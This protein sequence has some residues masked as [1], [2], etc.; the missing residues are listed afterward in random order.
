[1]PFPAWA[2]AATQGGASI[3]GTL[4]SA[5]FNN[6]T[7]NRNR[8]FDQQSTGQDAYFSNLMMRKQHEMNLGDWNMQNE[9][10]RKMQ[11]DQ[12][13][14][15]QQMWRMQNEYDSPTQQMERFRKAGLNPN[16]IYG[17][18]GNGQ[19]MQISPAVRSNMAGSSP[20]HGTARGGNF[21]APTFD[22]GAGIMS[23]WDAKQKAAQT[24]NI[25]AATE[26]ARQQAA[27]IG[28]QGL[29]TV[30]DTDLSKL[31]FKQ[32]SNLGEFQVDYARLQ[33]QKLQNEMDISNAQN[34]RAGELH[35][36]NIESLRNSIKESG[37]KQK[38]MDYDLQLR[39]LGI[40]SG[41]PTWLRLMIRAKQKLD[42]YRGTPMYDK[43]DA[44]DLRD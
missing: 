12:R 40:Y 36:Y 14:Y 44:V 31:D 25:K 23:I 8:F 1:M 26:V 20:G 19:S 3:G 4:I 39:K 22:L 33:N 43:S 10:N 17:Q 35:P 15:E 18:M 9:Y 2:A 7:N 41:D 6:S 27:L 38:L 34:A 30:A 24:D 29:K 32:R 42:E 21:R 11:L 5:G 28:V 16:L 37:Q 13:E